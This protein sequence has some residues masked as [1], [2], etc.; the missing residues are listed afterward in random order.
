MIRFLQLLMSGYNCMFI[1]SC[2]KNALCLKQ[3]LERHFVILLT[4]VIKQ[5][6]IS[7]YW[8]FTTCSWRVRPFIFPQ[9]VWRWHALRTCLFSYRSSSF[10]AFKIKGLSNLFPYL[11]PFFHFIFLL[12]SVF[13]LLDCDQWF[14][15]VVALNFDLPIDIFIIRV[16]SLRTRSHLKMFESLPSSFR[17]FLWMIP[18]L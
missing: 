16:L 15:S 10:S 4:K 8:F 14:S 5:E 7:A 6:R 2:L 9:M 1:R 13:S 17:T 12:W 3:R 18:S 11:Y